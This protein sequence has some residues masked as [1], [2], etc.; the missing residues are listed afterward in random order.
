MIGVRP[1][2]YAKYVLICQSYQKSLSPRDKKEF[3][4]YL[5]DKTI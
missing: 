3:F 4:I 5:F 2:I 1:D